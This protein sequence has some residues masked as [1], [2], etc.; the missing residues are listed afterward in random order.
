MKITK[1]DLR[2][3]LEQLDQRIMGI[4]MADTSDVKDDD[5]WEAFVTL[6]EARVELVN[7]CIKA[8]VPLTKEDAMPP[9]LERLTAN[10]KEIRL[11]E[12]KK[13]LQKRNN[14]EKYRR[15]ENIARILEES[16]K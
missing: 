12:L 11:H 15:Y 3:K 9:W 1:K 6:L 5:L 8:K 2:K 10:Q 13:L 4:W 7:V 14:S 16:G